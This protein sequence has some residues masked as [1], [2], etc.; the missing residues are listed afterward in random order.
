MTKLWDLCGSLE[1]KTNEEVKN[2]YEIEMLADLWQNPKT[3]L[4]SLNK[5]GLCK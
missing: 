4:I 2:F 1:S 5:E 3:G